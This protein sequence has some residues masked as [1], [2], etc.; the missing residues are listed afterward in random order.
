MPHDA[1]AATDPWRGVKRGDRFYLTSWNRREEGNNLWVEVTD[2]WFDP[3]RGQHNTKRGYMA[4]IS[5]MGQMDKRA[6]TISSLLGKDYVRVEVAHARADQINK[7]F[8]TTA[9]A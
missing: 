9:G 7:W 8:E 1:K 5:L 2:L 4:A 6:I 3:V